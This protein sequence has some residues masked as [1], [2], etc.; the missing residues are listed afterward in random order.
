MFNYI[1]PVMYID[2]SGE[3][4]WHW[5]VAVGAVVLLAFLTVVSCGGFAAAYGA[6]VLAGNG[7]GLIGLSSTATILSF[8]TAGSTLALGA[9]VIYAGLSSSSMDEFADYGEEA[10]FMTALGGI[11]GTLAGHN[12]YNTGLNTSG[13]YS[14]QKEGRPGS[15]YT[16]YDSKGNL[17]RETYYNKY[18]QQQYRIDYNHSHPIKGFGDIC[19]HIHV[20]DYEYINDLLRQTYK[21]VFPYFYYR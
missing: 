15:S 19:P 14:T 20:Y 6:I 10:L 7:I 3:D 4:W 8:A 17:V 1:T 13:T 12:V 21:T 5:G 11:F 18:G 2:P 16:Q 9:S